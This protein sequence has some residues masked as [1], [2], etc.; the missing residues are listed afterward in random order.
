MFD[1]L[2]LSGTSEVSLDDKG[3]LSVPV[4]YRNI[5]KEDS[6]GQCVVTKSLFDPC[7]WMYP[8][9]EWESVVNTL[10]QLPTLTD[11]LCRT[12]Q[13]TVLGNA[14]YCQLDSQG[15]ILLPQELRISAGLTKKAYLIGFN[16]KF[17]LWSDEALNKQRELDAKILASSI[18]SLSSHPGLENLKL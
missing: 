8:I 12:V 3:R 7:L 9:D 13:R 4:R 16:N 18:D 1:G 10:G 2:L 5:I 14:V 15:R 6:Q 17:E 11:A